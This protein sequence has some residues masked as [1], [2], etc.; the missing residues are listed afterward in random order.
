MVQHQSALP[1]SAVTQI[2]DS[3]APSK[4]TWNPPPS[5][6][7]AIT[8]FI[9]GT[10]DLIRNAPRIPSVPNLPAAELS[11]L[12]TLARRTDIVIK[13]A[14]KG[15]ATVV[16]ERSLYVQECMRL[17]SDRNHYCTL[18]NDP[19]DEYQDTV[20]RTI[21][22]FIDKGEL[23]PQAR[24]LLVDEPRCSVFYALPKIHKP[25]NPGRPIVSTI[26]C[27][28]SLISK[29]VDNICQP[30]LKETSSYIKDTNHTLSLLQN[31]RFQGRHR[32]IITGDV[33]NLYTVI[34]H[35]NGLRALQ[36]FLN[37]R[38]VQD[39]PTHV[40][41]KLAELVLSL[42]AFQFDSQFYRQVC[43]V[44]MG[45]KMGPSFAC[46]YLAY[47]EEK[48]FMEVDGPKPQFFKRYI[49]DLLF[50]F[51]CTLRQ[52]QIFL[53]KFTWSSMEA[54]KVPFLDILIS[55]DGDK[56]KTSVY[57]KPTYTHSYLLYSSYHAKS[58][59]DSIP[60]SQFLRIRRLCSDDADFREQCY[61]YSEFFRERG[62]PVQLIQAAVA[63]AGDKD[64][65]ELLNGNRRRIP[66][67]RVSL[68]LTYTPLTNKLAP[69][70]VQLFDRTL[71]NNPDTA[72]IFP[73][74]PIKSFRKPG[75]LRQ[76]LV[77]S[78][79]DF[80]RNSDPNPGT[81]PCSRPNCQTCAHTTQCS[82]I[83]TPH[84]KYNFKYRFNCE[85]SCVIYAVTCRRCTGSIYVGQP[86]RSL[87]QRF[88]EHLQSVNNDTGISNVANHF[89]LHGH[90][91]SD[92]KVSVLSVAPQ[93]SSARSSLENKLIFRFQSHIAPGL[94][95][96]FGFI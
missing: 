60:Y 33:S 81:F 71:V 57:S 37:K 62:Y 84:Y 64:R 26:S 67:D 95:S 94:N 77:H 76:L 46:L 20:K 73:N 40:V 90:S 14:D 50:M 9:E 1:T 36:H 79:L 11:A 3:S 93:N 34:D 63:K 52:A 70:I 27:P 45:T 92:M 47:L 16:W 88:R 24:K 54:E 2:I 8:H 18:N 23:P 17:L 41:V 4:S 10:E 78:R 96:A 82:F 25:E 49:D 7:P 12:N 22:D 38:A 85:T 5:R 53:N 87:G 59:R 83:S 89:N 80:Q 35:G 51:S 56:V 32:I 31:F 75:S 91:S 61:K 29:F 39:P 19:T 86:K 21:L 43:G 66:Q 74:I 65:N 28:T 69:K 48:F 30:I 72:E 58:L 55:P 6:I 13:P 15:G 44:A 68:V 42:N